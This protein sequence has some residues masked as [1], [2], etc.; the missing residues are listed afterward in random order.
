MRTYIQSLPTRA[1]MDQYVYRLEKYKMEIQELKIS[2]KNAQEKMGIVDTR[3]SEMEQELI[4]IKEK[5]QG[6]QLKQTN[7]FR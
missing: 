5:I 2:T 4:K 6:K 3:V 1:D 7:S